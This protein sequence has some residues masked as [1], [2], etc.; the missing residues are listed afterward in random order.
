MSRLTLYQ[1]EILDSMINNKAKIQTSEGRDYKV[2][3][4]YRNN[5]YVSIRRDTANALFRKGYITLDE[6]SKIRNFEYI[7]TGKK[8]A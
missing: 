8:V 1:K 7:Y 2:W 5:T 6:Q 4:V 3:L